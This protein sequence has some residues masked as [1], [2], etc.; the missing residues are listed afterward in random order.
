MKRTME[1]HRVKVTKM[2]I[3]K[4][5]IG[6]LL[7]KPIQSISVKELCSLA[8]INRGTFY[9]HYED[10][11]GLLGEIEDD[12]QEAF[13]KTLEPLLLPKGREENLVEI[14]TGIFQCLKDN[15][16]M[17]II[18]LGDY[19]DKQFVARLLNMGKEKC[20][21]AYSRYFQNATARQIE[22]FYSFASTGCIGLLRQWLNEG[23]ESSARE[24]AQTAEGIMLHGIRFLEK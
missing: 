13:Q 1:D 3:R 19:S 8:G 18:M 24:I 22:F 12:M 16:D 21:E 17:C 10:I 7:Q 6:L 9:T 4:A 23:M 15:S 20:M 2:L 14:C 5:F 11:Y